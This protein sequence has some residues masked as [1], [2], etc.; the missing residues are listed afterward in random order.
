MRDQRL[1]VEV[2]APSIEEAVARGA[3]ELGV[4]VDSVDVQV[5][6]EGGKGMFGLGLRQ[7]RVSA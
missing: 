3:A 5:L 1:T 7:P 2:T 4:P 6:D